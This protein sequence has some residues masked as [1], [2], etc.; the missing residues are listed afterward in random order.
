MNDKQNDK[1]RY[2]G[3]EERIAEQTVRML[4]ARTNEASSKEDQATAELGR[5]LRDAAQADLPESNVDLREQLIAQLDGGLPEQ[6]TVAVKKM[7][8][9]K[10]VS[11]STGHRRFWV[12]AAA[13]GL[14]LVGGAIAYNSGFVGTLSNVAMLEDTDKAVVEPEVEPSVAPAVNT[15][16]QV[17]PKVVY[18]TETRTR[19][20]P[21]TRMTTET[22]TRSVPVQRT[23]NETKTRTLADGSIQSY[24]VSVPYT[25]N[26]TQNYTVQVPA[27]EQ[28]TQSYTVQVPYTCL[29]YTSPSPRDA[30]LSRM[31]S[32]A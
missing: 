12:A 3:S 21:V 17:I 24:Q 13:S 2:P 5:L 6:V 29:L 18:R 25:E 19:Q 32:S 8:S 30:T 4:E 23:R 20:V 7:A 9:D 15:S 27:T 11:Q 28:I 31:P 26:V 1:Q 16:G 10:L 14:L 22:K